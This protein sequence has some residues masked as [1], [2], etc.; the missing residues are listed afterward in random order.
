VKK[1]KEERS[2]KSMSDPVHLLDSIPNVKIAYRGRQAATLFLQA[3]Q[4]ILW[5]QCH[6]L[7]HDHGF[8]EQFEVSP[9]SDCWILGMNTK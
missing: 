6:A 3:Y 7:V 1:E 5:K 9:R 2:R 4:L 8:P